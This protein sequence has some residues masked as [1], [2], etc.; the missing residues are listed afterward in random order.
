M[1]SAFPAASSVAAADPLTTWISAVRPQVLKTASYSLAHSMA[2]SM[3]CCVVSPSPAAVR[4]ACAAGS[5]CAT[6]RATTIFLL[7]TPCQ[8]L[9][10]LAPTSA[11]VHGGAPQLGMAIFPVLV[12]QCASSFTPRLTACENESTLGFACTCVAAEVFA[13]AGPAAANP[14]PVATFPA[15]PVFAVAA[16][17]EPDAISDVEALFELL[18]RPGS[19]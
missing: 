1:A 15:S 3:L 8:V 5:D 6:Y 10:P 17:D 19:R 7:V 4:M 13:A 9:P 18:D 12:S 11:C 16:C 2:W 14:G